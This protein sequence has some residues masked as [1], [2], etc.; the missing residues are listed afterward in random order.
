MGHRQ[1]NPLFAGFRQM[2]V[3]LT[4]TPT[5]SQP[6]KGAFNDPAFGEYLKV[7]RFSIAAHNLDA[8]AKEL[9]TP[10]NQSG[11][12]ITAIQKQQFPAGKEWD[13]AQNQGQADFIL[14]V[15]RMYRNTDQPAL[16]IDD[17]VTFA[18]FDLLAPVVAACAPFSVVLTLWLSPIKTL[19]SLSRCAAWRTSL[20]SV[21]W[22]ASHVP[23][24]PYFW[25]TSYTVDHEGKSCGSIRHEQP[26]CNTYKIASMYSRIFSGAVR[27]WGSSPTTCSHSRSLKSVGYAFRLFMPSF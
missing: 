8:D 26:L 14:P 2:L 5:F 17:E 18:S 13:A 20:R 11:A 23:L 24:R 19:G 3:I 4:Q 10:M 12:G 16:A 6:G 7:R 27:F 22:I 15:G 9:L 21:S 25:K 1:I